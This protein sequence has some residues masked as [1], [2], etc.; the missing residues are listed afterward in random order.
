MSENAYNQRRR[1]FF[2][3]GRREV[4]AKTFVRKHTLLTL[5]LQTES[6]VCGLDSWRLQGLISRRKNAIL[7]YGFELGLELCDLV[8]VAGLSLL[9]Q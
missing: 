2:V 9:V 1:R 7:V 3:S 8:L 4:V 5:H 6:Q